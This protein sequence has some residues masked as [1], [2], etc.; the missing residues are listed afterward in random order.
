MPI[1]PKLL[2]RK[3]DYLL[4]DRFEFDKAAGSVNNSLSTS[5]HLRSA[6]D[7]E[8]KLS[9]AGGVL[10]FAGGKA[11]PAWG[12]PG[13]WYPTQARVAGKVLF[14]QFNITSAAQFEIGWD[15]NQAGQVSVGHAFNPA[16]GMLWVVENNAGR[17]CGTYS[18]STNYQIA[19]ILRDTG[20]FYFIRGGGFTTWTLVWIGMAGSTAILYPGIA[21]NNAIISADN[22]LV[23]QQLFPVVPIASDS[24]ARADGALGTTDGAGHAEANGGSGLA[25]QLDTGV[26]TIASNLA[27]GAATA[28]VSTQ[29]ATI[30]A[31][32]VNTHTSAKLI[33]CPLLSA[34]G[35]VVRLDDPVNPLN[36]VKAAF[37]GLGN[38]VTTEVV[39]GTPNVLST[40]VKAFTAGD[41]LRLAMNAAAWRCFHLTSAGVAT[42]IASGTTNVLT[43]NFC[44]LYAGDSNVTFTN[45]FQCF[46]TGVE[47]QYAALNEL[48]V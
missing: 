13:L 33:A 48:A 39:A 38:V 44:G 25:W 8:G 36:Y 11:T 6:T 46:S 12:N 29:F 16:S 5:G 28:T 45:G 2:T 21:N 22:V 43:G 14:A 15:T 47:G 3:V 40:V 23:P 20:A 18:Q 35:V 42:L 34:G 27:V 19:V 1:K 4:E 30:N 32:T 41:T 31:G 17:N 10:T 24:F 37:D 7:A 26:W 9:I